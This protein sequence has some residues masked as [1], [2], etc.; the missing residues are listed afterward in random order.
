MRGHPALFP[1]GKALLPV[2]LLLLP[3]LLPAS[4]AWAHKV[5]IFAYT[6][7]DRVVT[8]SNFSGGAACRHCRVTVS[9]AATGAP[10]L[11]GFTGPDGVWSFPIPAEAARATKGLAI[12][13]FGG[14]GHQAQWLLEPEE[15]GASVPGQAEAAAPAPATP[16]PPALPPA[17]PAMDQLR[18]VVEEAVD[19][20]IAPL[21]RMLLEAEDSGP[22][23]PEIL[24]GIGW[25]VGLG[26]LA[27]WGASR[28]R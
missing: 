8:E 9:D 17:N 27:A 28:R 26:G 15:Y 13:V 23:L 19:A 25:L 12:Q 11:Q 21:K 10:L 4:P 14:E 16:C 1:G 7:G 22:G 5:R 20:K 2:L 24:G 18:R 6:E 3:T